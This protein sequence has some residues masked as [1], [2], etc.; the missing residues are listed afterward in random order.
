MLY[1][2]FVQLLAYV[3]LIAA[4]LGIVFKIL[5][6]MVAIIHR[7][8]VY[9]LYIMKQY[10]I[11]LFFA[12]SVRSFESQG[13]IAPWIMLLIGSVLILLC[14]F[15]QAVSVN[16]HGLHAV[17]QFYFVLGT[18]ILAVPACILLYVCEVTFGSSILL[19]FLR[20]LVWIDGIPI[21]GWLLKLYSSYLIFAVLL[22]ILFWGIILLVKLLGSAAEMRSKR[23]SGEMKT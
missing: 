22:G 18:N 10:L 14:A 17:E 20:I 2:S 11:I 15:I 6:L 12:F 4:F 9:L 3:V 1:S 7:F 13:T 23:F 19:F 5:Q 8:A 16:P 21:L